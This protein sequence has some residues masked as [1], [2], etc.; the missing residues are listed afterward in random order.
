M[1]T[2]LKM[3][4]LA[5]FGSLIILCFMV[6]SLF[7]IPWLQGLSVILSLVYIPIGSKLTETK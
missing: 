6:G 7:S 1:K 3:L 5:L 2:F 4:T